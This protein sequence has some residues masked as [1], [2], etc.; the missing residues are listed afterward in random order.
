MLMVRRMDQSD[1]ENF[2]PVGSLLPHLEG[3]PLLL[4]GA[5]LLDDHQILL[6]V[7]VQI[8]LF[9]VDWILLIA[10]VIHLRGGGQHLLAAV[11]P[12]L[13]QD[14]I[15]PLQEGCVAVLFADVLH[16]LLGAVHLQDELVVLLE[17]LL[18]VVGVLLLFVELLAHVHDQLLHGEV[19]HQSE[20]VGGHHPTLDHPVHASYLGDQGVVAREGPLKEEAVATAAAVVRRCLPSSQPP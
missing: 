5:D 2:L 20:D 6:H 12:Q 15:D 14:A 3:D 11:V 19:E 10:V 18:L 17:G 13:H 4:E 16:F 9:V 1:K 8:L 7:V